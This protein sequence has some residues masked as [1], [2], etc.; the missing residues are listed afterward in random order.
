VVC[1][2]DW[3]TLGLLRVAEK[4][5]IEVPRQLS[6]TGYGD[7]DASRLVEPRITTFSVPGFEVGQRAA[8]CLSRLIEKQSFEDVLVEPKFILRGS[9]CAAF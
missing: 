1:M 5:G 7:L 8:E 6:I 2:H 4:R 3:E 9:T